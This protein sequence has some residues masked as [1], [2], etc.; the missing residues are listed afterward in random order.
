MFIQVRVRR[1]VRRRPHSREDISVMAKLHENIRDESESVEYDTCVG[2]CSVIA[3]GTW[4]GVA[5]ES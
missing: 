5:Q 4:R 3:M 1:A 2:T